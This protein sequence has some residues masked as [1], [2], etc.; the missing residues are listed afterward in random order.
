LPLGSLT[1][2]PPFRV[3]FFPNF[4]VT[5]LIESL[6]LRLAGPTGRVFALAPRA[7][8]TRVRR[9]AFIRAVLRS[10]FLASFL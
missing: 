7:P 1:V 8:G 9:F 3:G 10:Y 4:P 5:H 2:P 6:S